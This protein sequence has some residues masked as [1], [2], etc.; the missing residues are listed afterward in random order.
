[1]A[2]ERA[3]LLALVE[4]SY[5]DLVR[6]INDCFDR[7]EAAK[8]SREVRLPVCRPKSAL[9]RLAWDTMQAFQAEEDRLPTVFELIEA[10]PVYDND[11]FP[12]RVRF[13]KV[14][15]LLHWQNEE[16][17]RQTTSLKAF[18]NALTSMRQT[19]SPGSVPVA[20][21]RV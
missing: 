15:G 9:Y 2:S 21:E 14:R 10:M 5:Q 13:D 7:Q 16:R 8:E 20:E 17:V 18:K 6:R 19:L 1:M 11:H 4:A 12:A 3:E